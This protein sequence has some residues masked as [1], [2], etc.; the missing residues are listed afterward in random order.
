M[1]LNDSTATCPVEHRSCAGCL[2]K[3]A[4]SGNILTLD[5]NDFWIGC[6]DTVWGGGI[7]N[8][9]VGKSNNHEYKQQYISPQ[10]TLNLLWTSHIPMNCLMSGPIVWNVICS[11][12]VRCTLVKPVLTAYRHSQ[13]VNFTLV[14]SFSLL[15][16]YSC[17]RKFYCC[18]D[19]YIF[20]VLQ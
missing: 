20:N 19:H 9:F 5:N 11:K 13:W 3:V 4:Q 18:V 10:H 14:I 16:C 17:Y 7:K 15:K 1:R 6:K 12:N 2:S 8:P